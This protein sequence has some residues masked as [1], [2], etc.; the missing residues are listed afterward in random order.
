MH[1]R[2]SLNANAKNFKEK[3]HSVCL[4]SFDVTMQFC[5]LTLPF[6][7]LPFIASQYNCRAANGKAQAPKSRPSPHHLHDRQ[8]IKMATTF[9]F[10]NISAD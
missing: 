3:I 10:L 5:S 6:V 7:T 1:W 4:T 2:E 8:P 9:Q